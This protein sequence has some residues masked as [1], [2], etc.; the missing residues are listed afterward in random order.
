MERW[1]DVRLAVARMGPCR[2]LMHRIARRD[3]AA[4]RDCDIMNPDLNPDA[5]HLRA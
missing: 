2:M 5:P 4:N 1:C 3:H